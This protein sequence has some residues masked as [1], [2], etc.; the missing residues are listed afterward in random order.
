MIDA[1]ERVSA[2]T[3]LITAFAFSRTPVHQLYIWYVIG[4]N[5]IGIKDRVSWSSEQFSDDFL[6][7]KRSVK[8]S[9]A[10]GVF[11]LL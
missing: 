5:S 4:W 10:V 3:P 8:K 6:I 11:P 2:D 1:G 7:N 9:F